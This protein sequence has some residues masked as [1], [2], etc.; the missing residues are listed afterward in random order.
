MKIKQ[1]ALVIVSMFFIVGIHSSYAQETTDPDTSKIPLKQ[2]LKANRYSIG[3]DEQG[4]TGEGGQWLRKKASE[5][6]IV[7][8]G[9]MHLTQEIPAMMT[10]LVKELQRAN[11]VDHL[12]IEVSPWTT[13]QMTKKLRKGKVAYDNFIKQYPF[14]V[15]FYNF[16]NERDLLLQMLKENE[17]EDPLWGLDQIF[18]FSTNLALDRLEHLASTNKAKDAIQE[19]RKAGK[20]KSVD[21]PRLK[22]YSKGYTTPISAFDPA[23]FDTLQSYFTGNSEAQ[24]ILE[25]LSHSIT[26]YR[27]NDTNNYRSNQLRARYLRDNFRNHVLKAQQSEETP[28]IL[29]KMGGRHIYRGITPNNALDVGNLAVSLARVM[30][31]EALNVAVLCGPNSKNTVFPTREAKC[32]AGYLDESLQTLVQDHPVL[33]DLS[34]VHQKLHDG[35]FDP[36]PRLKNLLWGFDAVVFI[37]NTTPANPIFTSE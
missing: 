32:S 30:G 12:A 11:E 19:V 3:F 33:F 9:E 7:S 6:T 16:E 29:I 18:A 1:L 27:T 34:G 35:A 22:K 10:A 23:T 13:E 25:E 24:T 26:I 14:A 2:V 31:G 36:S 28:Q 21:D 20:D 8:L 4:L 17:N 15:P 5:A 37:P